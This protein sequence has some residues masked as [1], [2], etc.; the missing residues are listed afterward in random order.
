MKKNVNRNTMFSYLKEKLLNSKDKNKGL[1]KVDSLGLIFQE[2]PK[3]QKNAFRTRPVFYRFTS[4]RFS[5]HINCI[6]SLDPFLSSLSS[7]VNL[8]VQQFVNLFIS[9]FG[10]KSLF[11]GPV[12][13]SNGWVSFSLF[14]GWIDHANFIFQGAESPGKEEQQG[15]AQT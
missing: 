12:L 14:Q 7:N 4:L 11:S 10:E 3:K 8:D 5:I 13:P 15:D 2:P 1:R 6:Q 9:L